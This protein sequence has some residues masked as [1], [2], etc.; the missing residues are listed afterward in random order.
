M[1]KYKL[2]RLKPSHDPKKLWLAKYVNRSVIKLPNA[3][4]LDIDF[5]SKVALQMF[6]NGPDSANPPQISDG[7]G[8]C[9]WAAA[10]N[11][12]IARSV[13]AG[14]II[15]VTLAAVLA[16][17]ASTGFNINDPTNTDNGT[18]PTQ[19]FA[20][21]QKTGIQL[22]DGTFDKLGVVVSVNPKDF[23][24]VMLAHNIFGGLYIGVEFPGSWEDAN[25]WDATNE[26]I[27][28]GHEI[29]GFSDLNVNPVGIRLYTWG[30]ERIITQ[31]ALATLCDDLRVVI[32]SDFFGPN[33]K[34]INGFDSEQLQA[35]APAV[36]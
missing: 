4:A 7:V 22:S 21:L 15:D 28:G 25:V 33:G 2:G 6:G 13:S 14:K 20:F 17:Y 3:P 23:E 18:D 19:G 24:E 8:D 26:T 16:G 9:F 34:A 36:Q 5:S 32:D 10:A 12:A 27:E 11:G 1:H 29:F 35:D 30:E 31:A